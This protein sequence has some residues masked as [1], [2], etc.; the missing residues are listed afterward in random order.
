MD[1]MTAAKTGF[2]RLTDFDGKSGRAEFWWYVLAAIIANVLIAIVLVSIMTPMGM[3]A[4]ASLVST[5][6][7]AGLLVAACVRR[8]R[9]AGKPEVLAYVVFG[10]NILYSLLGLVGMA[11]GAIG[12]IVGLISLVAGLVMLFFLVQPSA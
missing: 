3:P 6:V 11:I 4:I 9:D 8:L 12:M 2:G 10:L 7:G 1:F 5:L